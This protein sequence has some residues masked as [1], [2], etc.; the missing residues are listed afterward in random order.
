MAVCR[1]NIDAAITT[2]M[3]TIPSQSLTKFRIY[4]TDVGLI[5]KHFE[6]T[7]KFYEVFTYQYMRQLPYQLS[8]LL[9]TAVICQN[10]ESTLAR[11]LRLDIT[12]KL[13]CTLQVR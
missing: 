2:T 12:S 10:R 13:C 8:C 11:L 3:F 1:C 6:K 5:S 4:Q 7:L 9:N